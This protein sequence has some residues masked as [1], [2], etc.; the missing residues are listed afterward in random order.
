MQWS[1]LASVAPSAYDT[2]YLFVCF[3]A[4]K[5]LAERE[6]VARNTKQVQ[7]PQKDAEQNPQKS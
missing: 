3:P 5:E 7:K 2:N 1:R 4:A 6:E